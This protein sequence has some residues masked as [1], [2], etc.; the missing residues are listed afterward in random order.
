MSVVVLN[1]GQF[2]IRYILKNWEEFL[3]SFPVLN[4]S[5]KALLPVFM[6]Q[7]SSIMT[8]STIDFVLDV[9][10]C[11]NMSQFSMRHI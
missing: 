4:Y 1:M 7:L 5:G 2:S 10:S 8:K 11:L 9:W 6:V 3:E